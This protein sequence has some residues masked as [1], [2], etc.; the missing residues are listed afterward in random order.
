[1]VILEK[2]VPTVMEMEM[3]METAKVKGIWEKRE[4]KVTPRK[5]VERTQE[6]KEHP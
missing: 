6:T 3:E 4:A 2:E 5:R 1:L